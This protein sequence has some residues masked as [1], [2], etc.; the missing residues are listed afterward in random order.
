[1]HLPPLRA[2]PSD[3]SLLAQRVLDEHRASRPGPRSFSA[4]A[5]RVLAAHDWPGNVRELVNV[6]QRAMVACD[7]RVIQPAHVSIDGERRDAVPPTES[8][9]DVADFRTARRAAL[10][11]FERQYVETLLRKH[12][13]NVSRAARDARQDRRAFGRFI[14]KYG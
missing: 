4:G 10:D 12:H 3:I 11:A 8:C 2:R 14:K 5:L 13:G 6:V 9:A 7:G 1:V